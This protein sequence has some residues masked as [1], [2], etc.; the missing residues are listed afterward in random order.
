MTN[1]RLLIHTVTLSY[2]TLN[3]NVVLKCHAGV[4]TAFCFSTTQPKL[5]SYW[6]INPRFISAFL[7][8]NVCIKNTAKAH[9]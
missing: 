1:A 5:W 3:I 6:Y 2:P 7:V 9:K 8:S 4:V